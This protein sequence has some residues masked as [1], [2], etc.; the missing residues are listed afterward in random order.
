MFEEDDVLTRNSILQLFRLEDEDIEQIKCRNVS[1]D[2]RADIRITP[3]EEPCPECGSF[4]SVIKDYQV[5]K[6]NHSMLKDRKCTLYYHQRRYRCKDCSR[7]FL[8]HNPFVFKGSSL[9]AMTIR[10]VLKDLKDYNETFASVA[11]RHDIS[12][13]TVASIFDVHVSIPR[14][15]LPEHLVVDEVYAFR[16]HS[17]KYVFVML[18]YD[19]QKPVDILNSR[20]DNIL[21]SYF[22]SIPI[23][24]RDKVKVM[25]F[26]MYPEYRSIMK[27]CFRNCIGCVDRFHLY[28]EFYRCMDR[29]R[30]RVMKGQ[31]KKSD[32]YYL[33]KK[34]NW[35]LYKRSDDKD[36]DG[37]LLFD[38]NNPRKYNR[39]LNRLLNF[40][41]IRELLFKV[42]P[43]LLSVW[44]LRNQMDTFYAKGPTHTSADDL[45]DLIDMFRDSDVPE[46]NHFARTL[47][48]WKVEILNS[49]V[50][51]K[52]TYR[53]D[54][55]T[56]QMY[57]SEHTMNTAVLENRNSIIKCLKK[58]ANGY[59]CWERFRNRVLYV[60]D[61]D[62]TYSL[63]PIV[64]KARQTDH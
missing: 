7:T 15:T 33:T 34:F 17:D 11:R 32:S 27:R 48:R 2:M 31:K 4:S 24:E 28:Q 6:I 26:D 35:M 19:T 49:L 21:Y 12:P 50:I 44:N 56:G 13:T 59:T 52:R 62:A 54:K 47:A 18:D 9:S 10:N 20:R 61:K 1:G 45:S 8:E 42:H 16:H 36:K 63:N 46:M 3:H 60:L 25:S 23:E 30:I 22:M 5:K 14:K 37:K 41:D 29:V 58:N 55:G 43:D 57:V 51:Y 39:K 38:F 64:K 40:Y 53:I